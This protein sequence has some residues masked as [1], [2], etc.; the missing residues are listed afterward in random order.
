[1]K[2]SGLD[3]EIRSVIADKIKA[4]AV[5]EPRWLAHAVVS[6]HPL[7]EFPDSEW[8]RKRAYGDVREAVRRVSNEMK[9]AVEGP[10]DQLSLPGFTLVQCAYSVMR[11]GEQ[12]IVPVQQLS[13]EE[14]DGKIA[15]LER[16]ASGCKQHAAELLRFKA[17]RKRM[18]AAAN[19]PMVSDEA[20]RA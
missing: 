11:K 14:I 12:V 19:E 6:N 13:D 1:M 10:S 3:A 9:L 20:S 15:E 4:G 17:E 8:Y 7:P 2:N 18:P 16:M 5:L